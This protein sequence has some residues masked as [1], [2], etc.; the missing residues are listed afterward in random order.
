[1]GLGS[2]LVCAAAHTH[3]A[4]W[5]TRT[6]RVR[7]ISGLAPRVRRQRARRQEVRPLAASSRA[8]CRE[9]TVSNCGNRKNTC[10]RWLRVALQVCRLEGIALAS[11]Y[12]P[13]TSAS[14]SFPPQPT[15]NPADSSMIKS[16]LDLLRETTHEQ[17][18]LTIVPT[19]IPTNSRGGLPVHHAGLALAGTE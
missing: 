2:R 13:G 3:G 4:R 8:A 14:P 12:N 19:N 18:K 10:G 1:M 17:N 5:L 15:F 11:V 7:V 9:V 16:S 6:P